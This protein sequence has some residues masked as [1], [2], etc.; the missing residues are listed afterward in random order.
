MK[1]FGHINPTAIMDEVDTFD[2]PVLT[3]GDI[4]IE[5]GPDVDNQPSFELQL[6]LRL[7]NLR[8]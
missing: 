3:I 8:I 7:H 4:I 2:W 5:I 6:M 1:D